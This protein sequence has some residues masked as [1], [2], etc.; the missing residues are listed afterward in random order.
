MK[1][2]IKSKNGHAKVGVV[3]V[4]TLKGIAMKTFG[5]TGARLQAMASAKGQKGATM[6]EYV[7][8]AALIGVIVAG[9]IPALTDAISG[10]FTTIAT[11]INP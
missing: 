5:K 2:F 4:Q 11:A 10:A 1:N 6:I 9:F 7:L 3:S 8:L